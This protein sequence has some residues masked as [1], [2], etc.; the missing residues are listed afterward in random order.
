N[1]GDV[2]E[3]EIANMTGAPS[4]RTFRGWVNQGG[5]YVLI[6]GG[7]SIYAL[8]LI[9]GLD[10][11]WCIVKANTQVSW[12]LG[13]MLQNPDSANVDVAKLITSRIIPTITLLHKSLPLALNSIDCTN[14]KSS[15]S[16]FDKIKFS[17]WKLSS[18]NHS[19]WKPCLNVVHDNPL[20]ISFLEHQFLSDSLNRGMTIPPLDSSSGESSASSVT[21]QASSQQL[22]AK[23]IYTNYDRNLPQNRCFMS[24][25]HDENVA[26]TAHE[27]KLASAGHLITDLAMLESKLQVFYPEGYK[28]PRQ[29]LR[30]SMSALV[31]GTVDICNK[32]GSLMAFICS[33]MPANMRETLHENLIACFDGIPSLTYYT[34]ADHGQAFTCA[35]FS[36]YNRYATQGEG[37]PSEVH[38]HNLHIQNTSHTNFSQMIPY[39]SNDM[40]DFGQLFANLVTAFQDVF[41][42][43]ETIFQTHLP[44]EYKVLIEIIDLLPGSPG[45]PVAP[46]VSLVVNIN[47][48]TLSH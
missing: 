35:H 32:D 24:L 43:I 45:S 16:F 5:R 22:S 38:P 37:A 47:V 1:I 41:E 20:L 15:D 46:F 21:N 18:R 8:V 19:A 13:K 25:N 12:N 33:A 6:A 48:C 7:G 3:A 34:P 27:R 29:Y 36:W 17:N 30:I 23:V 4:L 31:D 10:L 2:Y 14:L 40:E 26:A 44:E 39:P 42:W 11:H 9:A 28:L